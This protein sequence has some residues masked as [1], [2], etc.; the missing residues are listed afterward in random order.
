MHEIDRSQYDSEDDQSIVGTTAFLMG[1][2]DKGEDYATKYVNTM[3]TFVNYY[4]YPTNEAER[5]FYNAAYEVINR[6][7]YLLTTKLPYDNESLRK[8]AFCSYTV[9]STLRHLSSPYDIAT[10][11][12]GELKVM[13][14]YD[15]LL[16]PWIVFGVN[17]ILRKLPLET[18]DD[19]RL[20]TESLSAIS[21]EFRGIET[22]E[23]IDDDAQGIADSIEIENDGTETISDISSLLTRI[24]EDGKQK[25]TERYLARNSRTELDESE[26]QCL[27]FLNGNDINLSIVTD[28]FSYI[29]DEC[30][31]PYS[32]KHTIQK[33]F[34][35]SAEIC[36]NDAVLR[37][38]YLLG[39]DDG[40][41]R[42]FLDKYKD[43]RTY[44]EEDEE[45]L[46]LVRETF[47]R[48][49]Y[50]FQTIVRNFGKTLTLKQYWTYLN[51]FSEDVWDAKEDENGTRKLLLLAIDGYDKAEYR[52]VKYT[53]IKQADE[54]L[55]SLIEI[56]SNPQTK[57]YSGML[58]MTDLDRFRTDEAKVPQNQIYIVDLT[59]QKYQKDDTVSE[60][61]KEYIGLLPVIT[62]ASNALY[63]QKFISNNLEEMGDYNCVGCLQN[64]YTSD[65]AYV[66]G[67][68]ELLSSVLSNLNNDDIDKK[69]IVGFTQDFGSEENV[70]ED[71]PTLSKTAV[72][73]FPG[74]TYRNQ[75]LSP[76]HMKKIGIVVFRMYIDESSDG[77]IGFMPVE[78]YVGT[79]NRK[80]TDINTGASTFIDRIVNSNSKYINC[81]SN[82]RFSNDANFPKYPVDKCSIYHIENQCATSLGLYEKDCQKDISVKE[83]IFNAIDLI[84]DNNKDYNTI[85]IDMVVDAGV[86][87]IAQFI[88]SVYRKEKGKFD[89]DSDYAHLFRLESESNAQT[90]ATVLRRY[91]SFCKTV[92]QD[93]MFIADG[94]RPLCLVGDEK[95]VRT[96]KPENT[97]ENQIL[98]RVKYI[99]GII[100][101]SYGAGY[102]NWFRCID[103]YSGE[104][105]WCPPSIKA[106]GV[107]IYTDAYSHYWMAPAGLRRGVMQED[108]VDVAFNPNNDEAGKIY[109]NNWNYAVSYPL[110]G[111]VLEGQKTFQK[112]KTSL[113]RVNVRRLF[114]GLE[115]TVR[116]LA[117][118]FTY[119]GITDY[120]MTRF[121][122]TM[123]P[124]FEDVKTKEG[125]KDYVIICD[126]R[127]NNT[128]TIENNELHCTIGV[129]CV[130]SLE[131]LVL[132][133]VATSQGA[134]VS[135][136][137]ESEL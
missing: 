124:I 102:C 103:R 110:G 66:D 122:D 94:L 114:L 5:Y 63:Y 126:S 118:Y 21:D 115:K 44:E 99:S 34:Y 4:G 92:R 29:I 128:Q 14:M 31:F 39:P 49:D 88:K 52:N 22:I 83:S 130:K 61:K 85:P 91:D 119:E 36:R 26:Q 112:N 46:E 111:I 116:Y 81:F 23:D 64:K 16:M 109:I 28:L 78:A 37:L 56:R 48:L 79:L 54:S 45:D 76:E 20:Q 60:D 10:A 127:N 6:G 58:D 75:K 105:Y 38:E 71:Q 43:N 104:H 80:D 73:Y 7:G 100:N 35:K 42:G 77:K 55:T 33:Y 65:I 12:L 30:N 17:S 8:Y 53:G 40:N 120:M 2:A 129:K 72:S 47:D 87:N 74:I 93:C 137:A 3:N 27:D 51:G 133:F 101:S 89:L 131:F 84:F 134:S 57:K 1:F 82:V 132:N 95:R 62:T 125:L 117:K 18:I 9:D 113:D 98:P 59:R 135:E 11:N 90:W 108:V 86:S 121:K 68:E 123:T 96:T 107:Y 41:V 97:I 25:I 69:K 13:N 32:T 70:T 67:Q 136:V 19:L 106:T 24:V 50:D 15:F